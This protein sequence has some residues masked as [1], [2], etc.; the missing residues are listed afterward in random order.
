MD[1]PSPM[2]TLRQSLRA[3]AVTRYGRLNGDEQWLQQGRRL[4][5]EALLT[6]QKTL[7]AQPYHDETLASARALVVY[8]FLESTSENPNAW[9]THLSGLARLLEVRGKPRSAIA[10]AVF[11]DVRF[12]LMCKALM[13]RE[14]SPFSEDGW[15]VEEKS[16]QVSNCGFQVAAMMAD[17]EGGED[18][19]EDC[20]KLYRQAEQLGDVDAIHRGA[21]QLILLLMLG[22]FGVAP[23]G[24]SEKI[25]RDMLRLLRENIGEAGLY[26]PARTMLP[27]NTLIWFYRRRP[28]IEECLRLKQ[29]LTDRG[30]LFARDVNKG[31]LAVANVLQDD[32]GRSEE[33]GR[34]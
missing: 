19:R 31:K 2:A 20:V 11:S 8:E 1:I 29:V 22:R 34:C 21:F 3:L 6:L 33:S 28:E 5:S 18:V 32:D 30:Y 4:Y 15:L 14:K 24:D 13:R 27:V 23:L 7:H 17:S 25:A 26:R 9:E 12:P 10:K 16:E